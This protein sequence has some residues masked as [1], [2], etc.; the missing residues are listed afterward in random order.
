M[1]YNIYIYIY[2]YIIATAGLHRLGRLQHEGEQMLLDGLP[3][4]SES[5]IIYIYIYIYIYVYMYTY[6]YNIYKYIYIYICSQTVFSSHR[7]VHTI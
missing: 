3:R 6:A 2:T 4:P 5:Y 1:Y 7:H